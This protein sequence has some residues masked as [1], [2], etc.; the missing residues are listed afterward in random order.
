[1]GFKIF[2]QF[3]KVL[4]DAD[5]KAAQAMADPERDGRFAIEDSKKQIAG[6][7][8]QVAKLSAETKKLE[9][10]KT[11][12]TEEVKK[13]AMFAK[14]AAE[15]ENVDDAREAL[16][17]KKTAEARLTTTKSELERNM[18]LEAK[19]KD[20]LNKARSKV[21]NAESNHQRLTTRMEGAKIREELNKAGSDFN[22]NGGAL[23]ALDDFEKDVESKEAEADAW[24]DLTGNDAETSLEDK[25]GSTGDVAVEDE[26]EALMAKSKKKK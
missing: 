12:E 19:L 16:T 22:V 24:E 4:R 10:R 3:K 23:S 2:K 8:T 7:T 26:L 11:K 20:Q 1:M 9:R 15:A 14:R 21:A 13:F 5:D 25:Y 17:Q 18:A 6:F